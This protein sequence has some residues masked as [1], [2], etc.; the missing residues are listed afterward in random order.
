MNLC[1]NC[2]KKIRLG[3]VKTDDPEILFC[4]KSCQAKN[5]LQ[6]LATGLTLTPPSPPLPSSKPAAQ[7]DDFEADLFRPD[8]R[9]NGFSVGDL[10]VIVLGLVWVVGSSA[11]ISW[12]CIA[13][14]YPFYAQTM[15][16]VIPIGPFL[17]G[18]ASGIGFWL[19]LRMFNRLPNKLTYLSALLGGAAAYILIFVVIWLIW[20]PNGLRIRDHL[21]FTH[22][23]Q[24]MVENQQV[25][26]ARGGPAIELGKW[27]YARFALNLIGFA[28][29]TMAS[30]T[31]AG[32]KTFCPE[33]RRYYQT[34][35]NQIRT[36]NDPELIAA[37][38]P[39]V[40]EHLVCG[41]V[42]DAVELHA[43]LPQGNS[44]IFSSTI[45]LESCPGCGKHKAGLAA[46]LR[47]DQGVESLS[48]FKRESTTPHRV[49]LPL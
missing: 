48:D 22:F 27:G 43:T 1:A 10:M 9:S 11:L 6:R 42:Q 31:I 46:T 20:E 12:I 8:D 18:L 2:G 16:F 39:S 23:L 19:S 49:V 34:V 29:G 17:C 35:G 24:I 3:G 25:R 15:W 4:T 44:G 13:I 37:T 14:S 5:F 28:L 41:R 21:P 30:V 7:E 36:S 45:S 32:S 33:C 38:M 26:A 47:H 40:I